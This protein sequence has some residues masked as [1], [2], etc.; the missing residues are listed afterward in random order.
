M[1]K[2]TDKN[3]EEIIEQY[4]GYLLDNMD[5]D[6]LWA[7]A[8]DCLVDSKNLMDNVALESEILDYYPNLLEP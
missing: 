2:I 5:F 6:T 8:Y 3:R 4:A 7:F 1:I